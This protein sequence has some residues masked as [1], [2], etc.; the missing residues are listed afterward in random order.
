M[1]YPNYHSCRVRDPDDF[2]KI[3]VVK[4][5]EKSNDIAQML[6]EMALEEDWHESDKYT[7][8]FL[9]IDGFCE[10]LPEYEYDMFLAR[11]DEEF[12][13][14]GGVLILIGKPKGENR[15]VTQAIRYPVSTWS[16][17]R[18]RASCTR[19]G[20]KFEP[21]KKESNQY[22]YFGLDTVDVG[23]IDIMP[24]GTW[25][26]KKFTPD[27]LREVASNFKSLKN[28]VKAWL[29]LGHSGPLGTR[30][31]AGTPA[32]GWFDR[33]WYD[34]KTRRLK[35]YLTDVPRKLAELIKSKAYR[36]V[37]AEYIRNFVDETTGK[38]Y[39]RVFVG[40]A[41][42]GAE[43]PA[44]TTNRTLDQVRALYT[45]DE[46]THETVEWNSL[47]GGEIDV[48]KLD[49]MKEKLSAADDALHDA[50]SFIR[51]VCE[52]FGNVDRDEL[53]GKIDEVLG[54]RDELKK[55]VEKHE[56]DVRTEK[57]D[58][59]FDEVDG[60]LLPKEEEK[61]RA[62][63]EKAEDLDAELEDMREMFQARDLLIK[64]KEKAHHDPTGGRDEE[65]SKDTRTQPTGDDEE[66]S[67]EEFIAEIENE[68]K[69]KGMKLDE[70]EK[71]EF[72]GTAEQE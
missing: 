34:E 14:E 50:E 16:E 21:A 36:T 56:G 35:G 10:W 8:V 59:L 68:L 23:E 1:P 3:R 55:L 46:Y 38:K 47:E 66:A 57:I 51:K 6:D 25:K 12:A 62:M 40:A 28:K 26:G 64:K 19:H 48:E 15:W 69:G 63:L 27:S 13:A 9:E 67:D 43:L 61:Y 17:A 24:A 11:I 5:N 45:N 44:V 31:R 52:K 53:L 22:E 30:R 4:Q 37:S 65:F 41:L 58:A 7:S 39:N 32:V 42:L 18:A 20:G 2:E 29:L 49:E 71:E 70:R 54:E 33:V 60:K 72:L